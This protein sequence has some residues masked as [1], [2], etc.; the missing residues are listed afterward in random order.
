MSRNTLKRTL[1]SH[2]VYQKIQGLQTLHMMCIDAFR[3]KSS[4]HKVNHLTV[5][6]CS[7]KQLDYELKI[8]IMHRN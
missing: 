7:I 4:V 8:S 1:L 6:L 2:T 3:K 5:Q